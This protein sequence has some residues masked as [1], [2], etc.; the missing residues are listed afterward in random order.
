MAVTKDKI[1]SLLVF[2]ILV[3]ASVM[4]VRVGGMPGFTL[5]FGLLITALGL[6]L[7]WFAESLGEIACFTRGIAIHSPPLMIEAIGWMFLLGYPVLLAVVM[8]E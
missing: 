4:S 8:Q 6:T 1:A 3:V 2:A 7:I 5:F